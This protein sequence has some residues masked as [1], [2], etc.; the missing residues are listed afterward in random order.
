MTAPASS[1]P[2]GASSRPRGVRRLWPAR[3]RTRLTLIYAALFLAGGCVLLGLTYGLVAASLPGQGVVTGKAP[4][5]TK[6]F[7]KYCKGNAHP[8]GN[9]TLPGPK[10]GLTPADKLRHLC[11][12]ERAYLA[13]SHAAAVHQRQ[14]TLHNLLLFSGLGLALLTA[15]SAGAG[16]IVSGR[17]LRPVRM[18][19]ETARRASDQHLGERIGLT[20]PRD[21]LKELADTF[22][23]MLARLDRAF[24]AQRRFVA[25]ASHELRTPLTVMRTAIDVTLAKPGHTKQ[26]LEAMAQRVRRSLDRAEAM[27]EA[28]LTLAVSEQVTTRRSEPA[29]LAIAADDALEALAGEVHRLDL[30]MQARL[31]PAATT[32]DPDLL[33]RMVANLIGN[34][35]RHNIPGGDVFVE[36]GSRDGEAFL[37][38]VNSGPVV[39]PAELPSLFE[40]FR[41]LEGRASAGEGAG[42]G[43]AIARSVASI[44]GTTIQAWCR[45]AGGLD[46]EVRLPG[47]GSTAPEAPAA[48][49]TR[50]ERTPMPKIEGV[51]TASEQ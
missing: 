44:H 35:V 51:I 50:P 6:E 25:D 20:G 27:I 42:L 7:A 13:G 11:S 46:I 9:S 4:M 37:R 21:E 29:D 32:G 16:W 34:A 48:W 14:R 26:Q 49:V 28:L 19:T 38:V 17:V 2:R 30:R 22:D 5:S 39:P 40:P 33:E 3:V 1:R 36:A 41:R 10:G 45:E 23:E 12:Q 31:E 8:P 15:I 18:I 47:P 24:T 43:L